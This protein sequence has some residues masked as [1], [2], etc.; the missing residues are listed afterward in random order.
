MII[1]FIVTSAIY[2]LIPAL[3]VSSW[4]ELSTYLS[5]HLANTNLQWPYWEY[6]SEEYTT[7][8]NSSDYTENGSLQRVFLEL[9]I[10]QCSRLSLPERVAKVLPS[11]IHSIVPNSESEYSPNC[12]NYII[13]SGSFFYLIF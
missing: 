5:I 3:D 13:R 9:L 12:L 8:T 6:W 2:E 11:T 1:L 7:I 4:R 10:G